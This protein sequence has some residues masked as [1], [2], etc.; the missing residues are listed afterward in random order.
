MEHETSKLRARVVALEGERDALRAELQYMRLDELPF[1]RAQL[2]Y[3]LNER[4]AMC[5]ERDDARGE[6]DFVRA[7]LVELRA[8]ILPPLREAYERGRQ[9]EREER[10][11]GV[12]DL[13]EAYKRGRQDEREERTRNET[14]WGV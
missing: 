12:P 13:Q 9:D 6:R 1:V 3:A 14:P 2:E 5:A 7:Q 4:D 11:W 10:P 8:E